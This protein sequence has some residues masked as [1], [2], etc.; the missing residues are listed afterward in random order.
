MIKEWL[1]KLATSRKPD[2]Q[3]GGSID[4]YLNRWF[5]IPR[6]RVF[7][8]YLHQFLRDDDDRALHDHP[9]V[10]MSWLLAG[11]YVEHQ[12]R[13]TFYRK[14]GDKAYRLPWTA[15]RIALIDSQPCWTLFITGPKLRVWGFHCPQG[16]VKWTTFV[17]SKDTGQIGQGCGEP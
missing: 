9:W 10:N 6:N 17:S 14:A 15:H 11:Q 12:K 8:I 7:N 2:F 4:P 1:F 3:V 16:W 13:H 5:V